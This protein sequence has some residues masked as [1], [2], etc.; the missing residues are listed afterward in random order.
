MPT[1]TRFMED[2]HVISLLVPVADVFTGDKTTNEVCMKRWDH[3]TFLVITGANG[4][5][6]EPKFTVESCSDTSGSNNTAIG[7]DYTS[8]DGETQTNRNDWA[9]YSR[10]T[11]S[12]YQTNPTSAV[13]LMHCIE[14]DAA[15]LS[16]TSNVHHE[17]CRLKIE[18]SGSSG[19]TG[20]VIC[21][22]SDPRFTADA[23]S[24]EDETS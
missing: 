8:T 17:Y 21:I 19:I 1:L 7:F 15:E 10:K 5:A 13:N 3:A 9:A 2:N 22:L 16:Q 4:S 6:D 12:G 20:C 14:V 11:S 18:E 24:H 23:D